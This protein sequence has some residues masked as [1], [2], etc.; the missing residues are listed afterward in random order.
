MLLLLAAACSGSGGESLPSI[1]ATPTRTGSASVA[2]PSVTRDSGEARPSASRGS[3]TATEKPDAERSESEPA[4]DDRDQPSA[5]ASVETSVVSEPAATASTTATAPSGDEGSTTWL[6]LALLGLIAVVVAVVIWQNRK[7]QRRDQSSFD[8]ALAEARWL[9]REALP[10]LLAA[11]R[12]ERR[13]AWRVARPRV[14]ALEQQ[15]GQLAPPGTDSVA[16]V[17]AQHLKTAVAGVRDALDDETLSTS[18]DAEAEAY[19]A[20]K[21][22]A[23]QL[24]QVMAE[25]LSADRG[26]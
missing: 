9:E 11:P 8:A 6:L 22:A 7:N 5:S 4:T 15:L 26:T 25:L 13:G 1:T 18:P 3:E 23:R 20:A 24:D 16:A 12:A 17:N 19:G 21:Q 10:T 14:A 2:L